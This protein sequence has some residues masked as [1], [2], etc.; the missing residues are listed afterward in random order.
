MQVGMIYVVKGD[1]DLNVV[2]IWGVLFDLQGFEWG[3]CVS[4]V[5]GENGYIDFFKVN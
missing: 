1:V 4:G 2:W 3:G 5:I